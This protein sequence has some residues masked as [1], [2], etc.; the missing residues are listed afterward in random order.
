MSASP[1][2]A[3]VIGAGGVAV[4]GT[5][6]VYGLCADAE[7]AAAVG[8]LL[9]LKGREAGKPSAVAFFEL[10]P[11]LAALPELGARTRAAVLALLPGPLTLLLPNPGRRFPL[12]GGELLG[13]RVIDAALAPG[14]PLLLTSANLAG[15]PEAR[16]LDQVAPE[17]RAGADL[18]LD[19]GEL[20]GTPST[21][22]DLGDF[23]REGRWRIVREGACTR[24]AL[25]RALI[26]SDADD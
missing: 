6:T 12:A 9:R 5:D 23:E 13:L 8:R 2:L 21:V 26:P 16:T 19:A 3:A 1:P 11:A 7:N 25:E 4:I 18:L 14:R 10:E 17:I 15:G 20:P 24:M 22:V